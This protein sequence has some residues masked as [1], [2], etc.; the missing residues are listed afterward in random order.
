MK[1]EYHPPASRGTYAEAQNYNITI[2]RNELDRMKSQSSL[3]D[4]LL[5][6]EIPPD[7][8]DE[9]KVV[10]SKQRLNSFFYFIFPSILNATQLVTM[11]ISWGFAIDLMVHAR[12]YYQHLLDEKLQIDYADLPDSSDL[13]NGSTKRVKDEDLSPL[14]QGG[15]AEAQ[16]Y[17][18]ALD[19]DEFDRLK[20]HWSLENYLL[21]AGIP[22]DHIQT[23]KAILLENNLH[24][25][26]YFLFPDIFNVK[27]LVKLGISWGFAMKLMFAPRRYYKHLLDEESQI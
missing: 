14:P 26:H 18:I 5:Y 24:N 20:A 22:E 10:L 13:Q 17:N 7:R 9:L 25:F 16:N 2:D 21:F 6:A 12:R 8:I 23:L 11:N 15:Y 1:N 19:N 3:D 27:D 4:Y